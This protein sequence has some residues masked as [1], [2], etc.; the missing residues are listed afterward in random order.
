MGFPRQEDCTEL[1]LPL[2]GDLPNPG[3]EPASPLSPALQV[4]CLPAK[5]SRKP[6]EAL[7]VSLKNHF[8]FIYLF[9]KP[10]KHPSVCLVLA[11]QLRIGATF[12]VHPWW[13]FWWPLALGGYAAALQQYQM[14]FN[15]KKCCLSFWLPSEVWCLLARYKANGTIWLDWE[16]G[17][18]LIWD[19]PYWQVCRM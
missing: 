12:G 13:F 4:D 9:L 8:L 3:I 5:A 7:I 11:W 16:L 19:G 10:T 6:F 14:S 18:P 1:P 2:S 17:T 15:L